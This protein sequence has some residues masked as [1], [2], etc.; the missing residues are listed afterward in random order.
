MAGDPGAVGATLQSRI[1]AILRSTSG[2]FLE[3]FDFM[4]FGSPDRGAK[5][6]L[7]IVGK[8]DGLL[9]GVDGDD[10][11]H[12]AED[13]LA[14]EAHLVRHVAEDRRGVERSRLAPYGRGDRSAAE[15]RRAHL[16]RVVYERAD[17]LDPPLGRQRPQLH[18]RV[19]GIA[20]A[21]RLRRAQQL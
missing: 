6:E 7:G 5:P 8:L 20:H 19:R 1:G 10:R 4:I 9:L 13:L 15:Q 11:H 21:H 18:R 17:V 12:R 16:Q 14:H 3:M 2:N